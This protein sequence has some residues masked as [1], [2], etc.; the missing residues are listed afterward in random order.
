MFCKEKMIDLLIIYLLA[1]NSFLLGILWHDADTLW[2]MEK[3]KKYLIFF[4]VG[5]MYHIL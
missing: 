3:S 1:W 2:E 5:S 4:R